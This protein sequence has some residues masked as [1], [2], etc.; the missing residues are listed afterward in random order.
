MRTSLL[1]AALALFGFTATESSPD[2]DRELRISTPSHGVEIEVV[3]EPGRTHV[4]A[5]PRVSIVVPE[6]AAVRVDD[7][8]GP[9]VS[10]RIDW[11]HGWAVWEGSYEVEVVEGGEVLSRFRVREATMALG[12]FEGDEGWTTEGD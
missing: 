7:L 1:I 11:D 5:G 2:A 9:S 12:Q 6:G 8:D 4:L 3:S 10:A